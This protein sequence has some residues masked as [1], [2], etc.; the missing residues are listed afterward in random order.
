MTAPEPRRRPRDKS[1]SRSES[2]GSRYRFA[3]QQFKDQALEGTAAFTH[4]VGT[5]HFPDVLLRALTRCTGRAARSA[6]SARTVRPRMPDRIGQK[7]TRA[8]STLKARHPAR[9]R[10][11]TRAPRITGGRLH[12]DLAAPAQPLDLLIYPFAAGAG[13]AGDDRLLDGGAVPPDPLP[14]SLAMM[15]A[16]NVSFGIGFGSNPTRLRP[17]DGRA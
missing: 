9:R 6:L 15:A 8:P 12:A 13:I 3:A 14:R 1:G 17:F 11:M 7:S 5:A 2:D 16:V 10:T 4:T